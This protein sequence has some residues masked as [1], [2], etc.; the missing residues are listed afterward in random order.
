[1]NG[2]AFVLG[3]DDVAKT[4]YDMNK[5]YQGQQTW[6]QAFI[7][8]DLAEEKALS[9]LKYD[10]SKDVAEAYA[11]S[12]QN[13]NAILDTSLGQG[14]KQ[15][16]IEQNAMN[17]QEAFEQYRQNY[18]QNTAKV[19]ERYGQIENSI[20]GSL[21]EQASAI[22]NIVNL[23]PEYYNKIYE[24]NPDLFSD[25]A[26]YPAWQQFVDEE[27]QFIPYNKLFAPGGKNPL[28]V[29][30]PD[31]SVSLT[32]EGRK[33]YYRLL[34]DTSNTYSFQQFLNDKGLSEYVDAYMSDSANYGDKLGEVLVRDVLGMGE[35]WQ[36]TALNLPKSTDLPENSQYKGMSYE[37]IAKST[38]LVSK[39]GYKLG[40]T[41][42]ALYADE[43][44]FGEFYDTGKSNT[45]QSNYAK[46]IMS[47]AINNKIRIGQIVH[48][49]YGS[50]TSV[51]DTYMYVGDYKFVKLV[52]ADTAT[53]M[54]NGVDTYLPKGYVIKHSQVVKE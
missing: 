41:V 25:A 49:N 53:G 21:N 39:Y 30:N 47:D 44:D 6:R 54:L 34:R 36:N 40:D 43:R 42:D 29:V 14:Y 13:R 27:G 8:T 16:A 48:F 45:E 17:L 23:I 52:G 26:K 24:N 33:V 15:Q 1:M 3:S 46:R 11:T 9:E 20:S 28:T 12:L 19:E 7:D 32:E 4:L 18:L 35:N 37:D 5:N 22:A 38:D 51:D 2:A 50:R 31:N 10:Y